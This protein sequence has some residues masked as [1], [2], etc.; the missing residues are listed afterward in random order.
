MTPQEGL[1]ALQASAGNQ[2]V[3]GMLAAPSVQR[4]VGPT[5]DEEVSSGPAPEVA[6]DATPAPTTEPAPGTGTG[7]AAPAPAVAPP[8]APPPSRKDQIEAQMKLS[9]TGKWALN[10][11]DKNAITVEWEFV[12]TGSFHSEGKIFLNKTTPVVPA[13]VV[14]MHE[15]QH[16]LTFKSGNAADP[17]KLTKEAFVKAKIADEAEAVVRQIE[18][19]GPMVAKGADIAGSGITTGLMD[20]YQKAVAAEV[21]KLQAADT[22]L[23]DAD[24]RSKARTTVR[25]GKVTEWFTDGT[26]TTSTGHISYSAHYGNTWDN[27]HRPP[28]AAPAATPAPEAGE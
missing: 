20:Q 16:A 22:T 25:N 19:A 3:A 5:L 28:A 13:A 26:F 4:H 24:A 11:I 27:A 15:A 2:A 8:A 1:V 18:G 17:E 14:M 6:P 21:K 12:G 7:S 10:I 23:S 9:D